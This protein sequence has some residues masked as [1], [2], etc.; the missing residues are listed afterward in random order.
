[1]P[2]VEKSD[3]KSIHS[4]MRNLR[5]EQRKFLEA[6]FSLRDLK[7]HGLSEK[8]I[9]RIP[10]ITNYGEKRYEK[11]RVWEFLAYEKK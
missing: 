3:T 11:Q 7:K 6:T 4:T 8:E 10:S 9:E 2:K 1:M 5:V